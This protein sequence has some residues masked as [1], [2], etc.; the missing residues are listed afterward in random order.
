MFRP[1]L[2]KWLAVLVL[3]L[4]ATTAVAADRIERVEPSSWWVGMKDDRLQLLVHGDRVADLAPRLTYPGVSITGVERVENPNYLFVNLRIAPETKPGSFRIDFLKGRSKAASRDVRAERTRARLRRSRGLRTPGHDL[5]RHARSLCQ[6]RPVERH[7][8]GHAGRARPVEAARPSRRRPQG[9]FEQSRLPGGHGLHA[10]LAE[11]G[12]GEQPARDHLPRLCDHR[13][14]QGGPALR[15][16]RGLPSA[17]GRCAQAWHRAGHGHGAE[18]LRLRAL[19]DAGPAEQGLVQS[20]QHVLAHEPRAR[21]TA[22]YPRRGS[23]IAAR[24]RTAG[25]SRRCRT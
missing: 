24:S 9:H 1:M 18:P 11:P 7:G 21:G 5:P 8:Q 15:H 25:S 2:R 4:A 23:R 19:V 10:A 3:A 14:L 6:R 17:R 12:A 13:F 20:R 22:G 16:Q